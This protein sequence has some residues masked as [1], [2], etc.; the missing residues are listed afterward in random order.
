MGELPVGTGGTGFQFIP[1]SID[2]YEPPGE[3]YEDEDDGDD[4][5]EE[6]EEE[7]ATELVR[8]HGTFNSNN[9][10]QYHSMIS[11]VRYNGVNGHS[12]GTSFSDKDSK[13]DQILLSSS[14]T[15]NSSRFQN[16]SSNLN[17]APNR[18][19][20]LL[21]YFPFQLLLE[22]GRIMDYHYIQIS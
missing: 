1:S 12:S 3:E 13:S 16:S 5:G 14:S 4:E 9:Q 6:E 2:E 17:G 18:Y 7:E 19:Y 10:D 15:S 8:V 21:K 20:F 22:S 11:T